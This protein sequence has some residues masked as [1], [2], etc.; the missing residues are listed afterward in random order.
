MDICWLI[1]S[2]CLF[3]SHLHCQCQVFSYIVFYLRIIC[4]L[5]CEDIKLSLSCKWTF[6]FFH[7]AVNLVKMKL[8]IEH[9]TVSTLH[10]YVII[11]LPELAIALYKK[12]D[13]CIDHSLCR[14]PICIHR[15]Y[16]FLPKLRQSCN[17]NF[18]RTCFDRSVGNRKQTMFC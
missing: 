13:K 16:S 18:G 7:P 1:L 4:L 8:F 3:W 15:G 14:E 10:C 5:L 11:L 9:R 6:Q 12:H 17:I 2:Q